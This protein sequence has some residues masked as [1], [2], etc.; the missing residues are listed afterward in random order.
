[1]IKT[2][3]YLPDELK[4]ALARAAAAANRSEAELIRQSIA[5]LVARS[6]RPKPRGGLFLSG[7]TTLSERID[8]P[9]AGLGQA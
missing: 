8:D 1:M 5:E 6:T 3:V 4:V 7:D 2:T 9:L